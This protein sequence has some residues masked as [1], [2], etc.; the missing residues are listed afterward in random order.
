MKKTLVSVLFLA[1]AGMTTAQESTFETAIKESIAVLDT[2]RTLENMP[3]A[4][5]RFERIA[6]A[7]T[8]RWEASYYVAYARIRH[9][10]ME[11]D[12]KKK[13]AL[14]DQA[15]KEITQAH[16]LN[17]DKSELYALQAY[18]Y[19]GRIQ[20]SSSRGMTY[21]Q[22]AREILEKA[23]EL[24]PE[25]PRAHFLMGQNIYYTP[26][27]FGG[28]AKNAVGNFVTAKKLYEQNAANQT[29]N[30]KWGAPANKWM[31]DKCVEEIGEI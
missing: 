2:T 30:P 11:K 8:Q 17:G 29:I 9:S 3:A 14:L 10:F 1:I 26:K 18:L 31:L 6:Q 20:V 5:A 15:Q 25:N 7:E 28:G 4:I 27:V 21:S 12:G 24:N 13:D 23:L 19:Q 22:K 16:Q